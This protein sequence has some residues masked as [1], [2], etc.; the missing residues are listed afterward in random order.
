MTIG[1]LEKYGLIDKEADVSL[2]LDEN[3]FDMSSVDYDEDVFF[4]SLSEKLY[5][6]AQVLFLEWKY[7]ISF[8]VRK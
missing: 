8:V 1:V 2:D 7:N 6:Y 4:N 5:G 3:N